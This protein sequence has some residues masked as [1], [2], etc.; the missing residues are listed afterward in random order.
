VPIVSTVAQIK[1][2]DAVS[3]KVF[4]C[5]SRATDLFSLSLPQSLPCGLE[6]TSKII[7]TGVF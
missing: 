2:L 1:E 6:Y 7:K 5:E 4:E 3:Q